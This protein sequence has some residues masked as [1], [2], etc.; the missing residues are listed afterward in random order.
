MHLY[1]YLYLYSARGGLVI[2]TI[3]NRLLYVG[4]RLE[5]ATVPSRMNTS[6]T[7]VQ[8]TGSRS[9]VGHLYSRSLHA[10]SHRHSLLASESATN[11]DQRQTGRSVQQLQTTRIWHV[12]AKHANR[13]DARAHT[14]TLAECAP[15]FMTRGTPDFV[16]QSSLNLAHV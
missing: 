5:T 7:I 4:F 13:M 14:S 8:D 11:S 2:A 6:R 1:L 16:G 9:T 12:P 10:A 3:A 15:R